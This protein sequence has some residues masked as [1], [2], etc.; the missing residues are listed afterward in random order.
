[1]ICSSISNAALRVKSEIEYLFRILIFQISFHVIAFVWLGETFTSG[2]PVWVCRY[3]QH[4]CHNVIMPFEHRRL[5][6][7]LICLTSG[8]RMLTLMVMTL[9]G[10]QMQVC[11]G[12]LF[13][14]MYLSWL[15]TGKFWNG[16]CI[17]KQDE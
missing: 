7:L 8:R 2:M 5:L 15:H 9:S 3:Y 13:I 6:H 11:C 4:G 12:M 10:G 1:M 17:L 14:L 16:P